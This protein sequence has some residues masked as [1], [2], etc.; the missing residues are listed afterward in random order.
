MTPVEYLDA[1][2]EDEERAEI[3]NVSYEDECSPIESIA[4]EE[5]GGQIERWLGRLPEREKLV[6]SMRFGLMGFDA[7]TLEEVGERVKLT[8]E[9][10]RQV[11]MT[12][13][14]HLKRILVMNG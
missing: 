7:Q 8:R 1:I 10:V 13:L 9:R 3:N 11:Q 2:Q 4:S 12:G 6:L 5:L 14:Y